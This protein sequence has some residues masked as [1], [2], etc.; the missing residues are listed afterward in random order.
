VK[1]DIANACKEL[2]VYKRISDVEIRKEEFAKTTT[3][4][5]KR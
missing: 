1:T 3:N 4:K 5:I 2:P